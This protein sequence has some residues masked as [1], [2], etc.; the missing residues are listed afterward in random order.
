MKA[1]LHITPRHSF[2]FQV[3]FCIFLRIIKLLLSKLKAD[4]LRFTDYRYRWV[5]VCIIQHT[6]N[7]M[8]SMFTMQM[9]RLLSHFFIFFSQ[10]GKSNPGVD[11]VARDSRNSIHDTHRRNY[12]GK[13]SLCAKFHKFNSELFSGNNLMVV[14]V[15]LA[16]HPYL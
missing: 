1:H 16:S 6:C 8:I 14:L 5:W 3:I 12:W 4:Q 9:F 7:S 10:F 11:S 13:S 15:S 2:V